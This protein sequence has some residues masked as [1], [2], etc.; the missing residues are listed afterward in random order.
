MN[1]VI[2]GRV[3][4]SSRCGRRK[5]EAFK[6]FGPDEGGSINVRLAR[7]EK[8]IGTQLAQRLRQR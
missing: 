5:Y 2:R 7:D 4:R 1:G 3:A 8:A 6:V